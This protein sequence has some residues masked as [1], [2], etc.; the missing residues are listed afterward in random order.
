MYST[1]RT[2]TSPFS[3][4][5]SFAGRAALRRV[6]RARITAQGRRTFSRGWVRNLA[7]QKTSF[8]PAAV[9][10]AL[11]TAH[12]PCADLAHFP[13]LAPARAPKEAAEAHFP[14]KRGVS[15]NRA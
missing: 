8:H 7:T 1:A 13:A 6:S 3:E 5:K 11:Q 12:P 4:E 15:L 14:R 9:I 2:S 10:A